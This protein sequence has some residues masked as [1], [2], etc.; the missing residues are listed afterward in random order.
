MR[1]LPRALGALMPLLL[2]SATAVGA[3][4]PAAFAAGGTVK[5]PVLRSQLADGAACAG[6]SGSVASAVPWEQQ[7]LGLSRLW[8]LGSGA[9]VTVAVVDTGVSAQAPALRGRVT[10]VG[11]AGT[12][13]V[14]HGSFVA[15]LIA[16]APVEGVRFAGVARGA[17]VVGVRGTD[18][19]GAA[20]AASVAEGIRAAVDA[21]ARVV[22]VSPA[23]TGSSAALDA[24]V[25]YAAG[26]DVLLVAAA[27]PDA[28]ATDA[29]ASAP[30]PRDY[31]PAAAPGV[32]SVLDVDVAGRRPRGAYVPRAADLA[33]PGDGVVGP[34]PKGAGHYIGSGASLAAGYVAGTAALV[35]AT[36]PSLT[37]AEVGRRLTATAYPADVARV[38]PYAA[39]TSVRGALPAVRSGGGGGG[40]VR[41]PSDEAGSKATHRAVLV[42]LGGGGVVLL[43]AW[44]AVVAPRGR[45]RG[46]RAGPLR[47]SRRP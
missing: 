21:G 40:A 13:C 47:S 31:W 2:T 38:D 30:P 17:R 36:H 20:T 26:R 39:L 19:R 23:L 4:A 14:G 7:S 28:P 22:A 24:A 25:R 43:V 46:W 6:A 32:L 34:G 9:G 15:G 1:R 18:E 5:L 33:A 12:D 16:A 41:L 44:A 29:S 42:A 37:A 10:A 45:A 8:G 3:T 27:V 35:R 11:G